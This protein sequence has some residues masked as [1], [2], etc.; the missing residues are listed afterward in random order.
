MA[1]YGLKTYKSDGTTVILQN[2]TKSGVFGEVYTYP[3]S[4]TAG[5]KP[6]IAFPQYAGRTIRPMQLLPGGHS[7]SVSY[8]GGVPTIT[9]VE[10]A[11][12]A[13]GIT[14]FYYGDTVL[15]IFVK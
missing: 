3:K 2:S 5:T 9:F 10:N 14:Q 12:I 15:Y 1:T 13:S 6:P 7:W 11:D 8:P 4:G